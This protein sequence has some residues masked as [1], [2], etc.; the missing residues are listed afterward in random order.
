MATGFPPF[1]K[2]DVSDQSSIGQRWKKWIQR[3]EN[4]VLAMGITRNDRKRAILLHYGGD[5][6]YNIF[7]TLADTG[8]PNDYDAAKTKLTEHFNP[9]K[10]L[11]FEIY[12]FRQAKQQSSE[13]M[14]SYHTRLRQL[15]ENCEFEDVDREIKSQVIQG[16][17]SSR[18]RR[19]ALREPDLTLQQIL[20]SARAMEVSQL[21]ASGMEDHK[22]QDVHLNAANRKVNSS[23]QRKQREPTKNGH[24]SKQCR[25]GQKQDTRN[26][27]RTPKSK[28]P[29]VNNLDND[30]SDEEYAFGLQL[31]AT[32]SL[33]IANVKINGIKVDMLV[34]SGASVTVMDESTFERVSRK[35]PI[36]LSKSNA[37]VHAYGMKAA[38]PIRGKFR[39]EIESK[40][41]IIDTEILVVKSA[42]GCLLSCNDAQKLGL[43][44]ITINA[45][46]QNE[47]T[48]QPS[49]LTRFAD[50]FEGIGKLKDFQVKLHIDETVKPVA[51]PHRRIPFHRRKKL[52][53]ELK[54]LEEMDIIEK[55]DGPTPWVSPIL[56]APKP[57][58]PDQVRVFIQ[59]TI[60]GIPG[61]RNISDDI[62]V[63]GKSQ[64]EHDSSLQLLL[65]RLR[66][67]NLTLNKDKCEFNKRKLEFFGFIFSENGIS[68]DPKKVEA[69]KHAENPKN[70]SE[71]RSFL[72]MANYC[73]RF[74]KDF[75]TISQPLRELTKKNQRWT[76]EKK[77][78]QAIQNIKDALTSSAVMSYF[79]PSKRTEVIVDASPVGLGAIL[80]QID[81]NGNR[82]VISY[83]NHKPL[84]L[85]FGN[86]ASKPPAR[87]E[88]WALRLQPY[89]FHIKYKPGK[90]NL[91]D[92]ISR[93]PIRQENDKSF[94]VENCI[95][96]VVQTNI[97]KS[98]T[99]DEI[100]KASDKDVLI[101]DIRDAVRS[102]SWVVFKKSTRPDWQSVYKLKDELTVSHT[103]IV[104]RKDKLFV[105]HSLRKHVISLAHEG[106][107]GIVKTKSLLREKVWFPGIDKQVES[108]LKNCLPC[109]VTTETKHLEPLKMSP[110]PSGPWTELSM[111]FCG[112][113]PSGDYLMVVMDE[114]SRYPIV[115]FLKSTSAKAVIPK[116]DKI[117]AE[118]G[119]PKVLK[120]DNGPLF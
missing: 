84:E 27:N 77:H 1:P 11:E 54:K 16:C 5:E 68:A 26:F 42:S 100:Q 49:I 67:R 32:K 17:E 41:R 44:P 113:F 107:Q 117:F 97:P 50:R 34:D 13:I 110:L 72:G 55:V 119:I 85:I 112:P 48:D 30:S 14:D 64:E 87:I 58:N 76:W 6:V 70:A 105:P 103:G 99:L 10:N 104:L 96:F 43:I 81:G 52:E 7:D 82:K 59:Q 114:Y 9:K 91:S 88:R 37:K 86:P 39:A 108:T 24:F 38:L 71:M 40:L 28:K 25:S 61:T 80:T 79:V 78:E 4:F 93:H 62:I 89:D 3:F 63:Y 57:K 2:F 75:A 33:P 65:S 60:E 106:H 12:K 15:A 46:D 83:G 19:K 56:V 53:Q 45:V 73:A 29:G 20:D 22:S 111:D 23:K 101:R 94:S 47:N 118:F 35:K 69:I 120:T 21:Q 8:G 51:Q 115:D 31:N 90:F 98:M 92:Y 102:G 18:L 109:Q 66:E 95:N 36:K 116:L 74:I